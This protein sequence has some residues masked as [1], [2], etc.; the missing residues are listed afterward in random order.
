[1]LPHGAVRTAAPAGGT[2]LDL[3][4][5]LSPRDPAALKTFVTEVSTPGS[6]LYHHY[7]KT[8]EFRSAYGAT[9]ATVSKVRAALK[10]QG[11]T[12]GTLGSDG[13]T[14]PVHTTVGAA[15]KAFRTGFTGFRDRQGRV[16]I[17]N[18]QAPEV[19]GDVAGA[20]TAVTGLTTTAAVHSHV[21]AAP[22]KFT[23]VPRTAATSVA[24]HVNGT[25][26][27]LCSSVKNGLASDMGWADT[28]DY[29]SP[30]SLAGAYGMADQP[31]VGTGVTVGVFELESFNA[32]DIA[33]YQACYGTHVPVS[34]VKVDGGAV[35][36]P[37]PD[38]WIGLE[39]ALDIED[40]IGLVPQAS[41]VVYQGPDAT[42]AQGNASATYQNILD[43][44][45][46]MVTDN[47]ARVLSTSWGSC[48][49]DTPADFM[50]A[51][52][53]IFMQAAAQGQTVTAASGDSGSAD[54][55]PNVGSGSQA[56]QAVDD[57]A[58]QPYVLAVGGTTMTGAGGAN[59]STWLT[60]PYSDGS[61]G[62]TG[63][64]V[65]TYATLDAATG[66]Q[67]WT[68][69][70]G[71]QDLCG[72]AAGR[73][74]RQVPDVSALAD[75]DT[76]YLVSYGQAGDG[77]EYWGTLGGTSGASPTWAALIAQADLDLSCAANGSVGW[78]NPAL[79]QLPATAFRD[80]TT[81][82]N[83]LPNVTTPGYSAGTGYDM[84]TG[85]GT[86]RARSIIPA[87]CKAVP[88]SA[89]GT[90]TSVNPTRILDTRYHVGV[91]TTTPVKANSAVK[92]TVTGVGG[93][94]PPAGS[95]VTAVVLNTT[96]VS[97]TAT[98][99]LIAYPDG[100]T[101]P[102]S[103][104]LNWLAGQ[105]IPNLVTVP[106]GADGKVDLYNSSAGTVHFVADV[107]GYFSTSTAGDT[108]HPVGPNRILDTRYHIGVPT[109][110]PVPSNGTVTVQVAGVGEVPA[111]GATS[112]VL[113][114]T[115]TAPTATGHLIAYPDGTA[116]PVSSNINWVKGE[117]RP[118]LVVL[119]IGADGKVDLFNFGNGTVHFV[120]DVFGYYSADAT[121]ATFHSAG[122]SRLL[123]TRYGV[124]APAA[125][126]LTSTTDL[127]LSLN[128]GNVLANATAVVLN[129]T[130]AN[131][132]GSG[133]LTV[134]PDG[135]ARPSASSLN[136]TKNEIV[137]NLVTVPVIDGKVDFHVNAGSVAV[138]ADL[139]GYYTN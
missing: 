44:Y 54:C 107:F 17:A 98:G 86:P 87:L 113:N 75:P 29:W 127:S 8:G 128:D 72:A 91:S 135:R 70:P 83:K 50:A 20:I 105:I 117:T 108:Y 101:M 10:A 1:A 48:E 64:G 85:L 121:G 61:Y 120:A 25:T 71:Y 69:G 5:V 65:S 14:L 60:G 67:A 97:P 28:Q 125:A 58:S 62:A 57:P 134:W 100:T 3:S 40:L 126:A 52:N 19:Q 78:T 130:V 116:Q 9:D 53:Q 99:H 51:E 80:I 112:V 36:P 93:V 18:T 92:L 6:P 132:S 43:V 123:D 21:T 111:G 122:P 22:K 55:L 103:S 2:A 82:S 74:C 66:Y 138:I 24:P 77:S 137:A 114:V 15:A 94:T 109:T 49:Q 90:F 4:V 81:G 95:T 79:Y 118:N 41:I 139:F 110:T 30:R 37:N 119:P 38:Q 102:A 131:G 13:L 96:A 136:W 115:A 104:N 39:S 16:G 84:T 31:N 76:G 88:Q 106:V 35:V 7:L 56:S 59:Q 89:A 133:V 32:K 23:S 68:D 26:P 129:V 42:D 63:G 33:A 11:L 124:G 46:K 45:Q 73:K 12:A 47:R 34:T 27:A